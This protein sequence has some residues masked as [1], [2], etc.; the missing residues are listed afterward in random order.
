MLLTVLV[1]SGFS[2]IATPVSAAASAGDL[3]KKDGLSAVYY[4]GDDGKRY[5]FP[6]E[7]TYKS[8]YSDFSGVVTISSDELSS[9]PLGG[10]VVVRPG[11]KLVK[12]T[13]D[14]KVYA[15]EANGVLRQIPSE[16][17]AIALYGTDWAKRV[18]DVADSFFINYTIG[19]PLASNEVPMGSLVKKTGD[20]SIY[21]YD[22]TNYRLIE[23]EV[24]FSANRFQFANV[25]TLSTFT[26]SG[27]TITGAETA[28][29]KTSQ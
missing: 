15:V 7:A 23:D 24:A 26:A 13:T 5:V 10:N 12:I 29:I 14:P 9:Y 20:S 2:A 18:I 22:G 11:T 3:I 1:M 17:A 25:L 19:S 4:L 28:I 21:Y 27:S 16:A 6:N 8:W